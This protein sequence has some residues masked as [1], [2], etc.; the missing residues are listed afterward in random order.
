MALINVYL[1]SLPCESINELKENGINVPEY[2]TQLSFNYPIYLRGLDLNYLHRLTSCWVYNKYNEKASIH[3][4]L[5]RAVSCIK[6]FGK[7][8]SGRDDSLLSTNELNRIRGQILLIC[9][10]LLSLFLIRSPKL[11]LLRV[12]P[13]R[14][15][16]IFSLFDADLIYLSATN[17]CLSYLTGLECVDDH[18]MERIYNQ[19]ASSSTNISRIMIYG[20][21][22]SKSL[23][24]L[25]RVQRE[26]QRLYL[27]NINHI[28]PIIYWKSPGVGSEL[29]RKAFLITKLKLESSCGCLEF[30]GDFINL[31]ELSVRC[32]NKQP[33]YN[34]DQITIKAPS[35]RNLKK[36]EFEY[37][38]K[39][40][41]KFIA[42]LIQNTFKL[43]KVI[44][45]GSRIFDTINVSLLF[46]SIINSCPYLRNCSIPIS[47]INP[48]LITLFDSCRHLKRLCLF[49]IPS[50]APIN[51]NY[52]DNFLF[53]ILK[54]RPAKLH[55]LELI[56]CSF[57]VKVWEL[58]L[59]A[60]PFTNL[61]F[62]SYLWMK[63]NFQP[64]GE[65]L[66]VCSIYKHV[67]MLKEFGNIDLFR[68]WYVPEGR[69]FFSYN[70][71]KF[72]KNFS[73]F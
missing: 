44:V 25:I 14:N 49:S 33:C 68:N 1:A 4:P 53:Q 34:N 19:L 9:S 73:H 21:Q 40:E 7:K 10:K 6:K 24:K 37:N 39:Y 60:Q 29:R 13:K 55:T 31:E 35:L 8:F 59:R 22:N 42:D 32:L 18:D 45:E 28:S 17:N 48:P 52:C 41:I 2:S 23:A 47:V 46:E 58:F 54:S 27:V 50:E 72:F 56:N 62:V 67:G 66:E 20:N 65:F 69:Y 30:L 16:V 3:H 11:S 51:I 26:L 57:S 71:I 64:S 63:H 43:R 5:Q 15:E 12:K 38:H 70:L 36:L 61:K